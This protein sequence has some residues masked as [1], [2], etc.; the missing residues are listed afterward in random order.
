MRAPH[1]DLRRHHFAWLQ[2]FG[3]K[4]GTKNSVSSGYWEFV[5]GLGFTASGSPEATGPFSEAKS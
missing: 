2:C 4:K 5:R 3:V 1:H